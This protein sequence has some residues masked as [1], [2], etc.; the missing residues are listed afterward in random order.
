MQKQAEGRK[1]KLGEGR[2]KKMRTDQ[3]LRQNVT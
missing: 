3:S 1:K 2:K